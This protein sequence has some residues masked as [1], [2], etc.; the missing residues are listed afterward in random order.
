M[1]DAAW[2]A[3]DEPAT[4][5]EWYPLGSP[6][7][8]RR[9]GRTRTRLLDR[10]IDLTIHRTWI[11][12]ACGNRSLPVTERL[13]YIWTTLGRPD[14]A[15]HPVIEYYE[16]DRLVMNIW[17][18]PIKCSGLRLIDNVIDN[19]HF[20]FVHPGVLGDTE[21][22]DQPPYINEVD[23]EGG[24]WSR[25]HRAWLPLTNSVA[26]YTYSIPSPYSVVL[27][28]HRAGDSFR[29]ER[30]D[31][32][33]V[34]AQPTSQDACIAHKMLAFVAE[35][36]M[37]ETQLRSDQ[38][39]ISAQDKYVLERHQNRKLPLIGGGEV[40]TN[41]DSASLAYRTWLHQR[42]VRYGTLEGSS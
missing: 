19:A 6:I 38:Q 39:A 41:V 42:G 30:Y 33:C 26:E 4:W 9:S 40:S 20:P 10:D 17:S 2:D 28:I 12:A 13:G 25:S 31:F 35:P 27:M 32:L 22:L 21:H 11:S 1:S 16:V 37:D 36:W 23:A 15:P 18:T 29:K 34:F 14:H 3:S 8:L 5:D 24:F 7:D